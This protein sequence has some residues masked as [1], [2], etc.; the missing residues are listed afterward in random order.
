MKYILFTF[1]FAFSFIVNAQNFV[2]ES[3]QSTATERNNA[4]L[5]VEDNSG[6]LHVVYY[7]NGIYYSSSETNGLT[8]STPILVD[9][10]GRN[11]SLV[12]DSNG[13]LHLVYQNGGISAFDIV[14]RSYSNSVWSE[15]EVVYHNEI[16]NV[17]RPVLA[18]DTDNNLHCVWQRAGFSSTPNSEIW[19]SK[20]TP[21]D[22]WQEAANISNSYGASEYPTL[23]IDLSNNV[24]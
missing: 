10:I 20:R 21:N 13:V 3:L 24:H 19:Y 15:T 18:I 4:R 6:K 8:W 23:T 5:I 22:G 14:Y 11:P 16:S 17:S 12:V 9:E 1:L 7:N 2:G